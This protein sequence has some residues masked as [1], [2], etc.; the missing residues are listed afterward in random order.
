[1]QLWLR[2]SWLKVA[3]Q[4]Y[5][6]KLFAFGIFLGTLPVLILG[7]FAYIKASEIVQDKLNESNRQILQQVQLN[8]EQVQKNIDLALTQFADSPAIVKSIHTPVD[9]MNFESVAMVN[10]LAADLTRLQRLGTNIF[11]IRLISLD[12]RWSIGYKGFRFLDG[13][14]NSLELDLPIYAG[15]DRKPRWS[16]AQTAANTEG[17]QVQRI[18]FLKSIPITS[19]KPSGILEVEILN[20]EINKLISN[21]TAA[22][23]IVIL[24]N[25]NKLVAK[26]EAE[27]ADNLRLDNFIEA[28]AA[29][30]PNHTGHFKLDY[31]RSSWGVSYLES[32]YSGWMYA[33]IVS[34]DEINN[35]SSSS[36]GLLTLLVCLGTL[37]ILFFLAFLGSKKM[38]SPVRKLYDSV[39]RGAFNKKSDNRTNDEFQHIGLFLNKIIVE[40]TDSLKEYFIQRL[41]QGQVR[42]EELFEKLDLYGYPNQHQW[43]CLFVIQMDTLDHSR[44]QEN[45]QDLALF[46]IN[47][48][49]RE[50]IPEGYRIE[51]SIVGEHQVTLLKSVALTQKEALD[52]VFNLAQHIQTVID[53]YL[54]VQ[55]SVGISRFYEQFHDSQKAYQEGLEALKYRIRLSE[56]GILYIDNIQSNYHAE[57]MFPE[58]MI[59][60]LVDAV[61]LEDEA[62]AGRL[63]N[64]II[65]DLSKRQLNVHSY[66]LFLSKL[67]L[68]MLD[69]LQTIGKTSFDLP[70]QGPTGKSL[71]D[72]LLELKTLPDV[73]HW[74]ISAIIKP[75]IQMF[76]EQSKNQH[77]KIAQEIVNM[78]LQEY[79][80][81]LSLDLCASRLHYHPNYVSRVFHQVTG[82]SFKDYLAMYRLEISKQLLMESEKTVT[83]ISQILKY[84]NPQNFIRYFKSIEGITPGQFR[85]TNRTIEKS[86][87]QK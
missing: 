86:V 28:M 30:R 5:L 80:T 20:Y 47:N 36:I 32:G 23:T 59:T 69:L 50:L 54:S 22:G 61:R 42:K 27:N 66:Q 71:F 68:R 84:N 35:A 4:S 40:Q 13:E 9:V 37:I 31:N 46:A 8:V 34:V 81:D 17:Q 64:Q 29:A 14:D 41:L 83:E 19:N 10:N 82:S 76:A 7:F 57:I 74:F 49:V 85:E 33:Y 45:D 62:M 70:G 58:Q 16:V 56:G 63:L 48:I 1:M 78:I 21:N 51:T 12:Y 3:K 67:L 73:E 87:S 18:H 6:W 39:N 26:Q 24:D 53:Q 25:Q 44:F 72:Q 43:L 65:S 2:Q 38:Y 75:S 77:V 15:I 60:K 79:N 11:D 52:H 55:I